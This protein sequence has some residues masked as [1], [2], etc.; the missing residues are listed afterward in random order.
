L[1]RSFTEWSS[2]SLSGGGSTSFGRPPG[3][4]QAQVPKEEGAAPPLEGAQRGGRGS[5]MPGPEDRV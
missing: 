5:E 4:A 1:R 3:P 2:G